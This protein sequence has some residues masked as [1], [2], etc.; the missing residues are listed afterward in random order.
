MVTVFQLE[1]GLVVGQTAF[2]NGEQS[3]IEAVYTLL[4]QLQFTGV[5]VSLDALHAQKKLERQ[6]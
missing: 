6:S 1:Q 5:T 4:E 2:D 3:E